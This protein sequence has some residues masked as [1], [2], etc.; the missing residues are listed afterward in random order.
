M[1]LIDA[2]ELI[3]EVMERYCRDCGRRKGLRKG[4]RVFLYAIGDV[5]CRACDRDDMKD[6]ID[7]APTVD[8]VPVVHGTWVVKGQDIFCSLCGE[9]SSYTWYGG[10][11]FSRY[12]P[13]CGAKMDGERKDDE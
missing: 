5:P 6:E 11:K 7:N 2:D 12:C 8:A 3:N 13:N 1:R 4:K 9:E 10:S